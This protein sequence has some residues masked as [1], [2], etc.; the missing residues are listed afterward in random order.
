M[1]FGRK[2]YSTKFTAR[3]NPQRYLLSGIPP[4]MWTRVKAGARQEGISVRALI[5]QLLDDWLQRRIDDQVVKHAADDSAWE[6]PVTVP[7][8][9]QD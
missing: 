3:Q 6:P 1:T 4:T 9:H 2:P 5:L 8:V 7:P